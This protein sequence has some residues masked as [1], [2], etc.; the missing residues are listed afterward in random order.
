MGFEDD[1]D[2]PWRG[3]DEPNFSKMALLRVTVEC[4]AIITGFADGFEGPYYGAIAHAEQLTSEG[5]IERA[6][7]QPIADATIWVPTALGR[8]VGR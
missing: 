8:I 3:K 2:D 5:L 6:W 1:R 4:G 7:M